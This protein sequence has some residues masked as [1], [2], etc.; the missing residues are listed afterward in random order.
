MLSYFVT[1]TL[2]VFPFNF[3]STIAPNRTNN[4]AVVTA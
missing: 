1:I 2:A 4:F 3:T